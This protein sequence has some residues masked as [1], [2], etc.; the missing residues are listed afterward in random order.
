LSRVH[1]YAIGMDDDDAGTVQRRLVAAVRAVRN[2]PRATVNANSG[3]MRPGE[4]RSERGWLTIQR[5][6]DFVRLKLEDG[7]ARTTF[8][9]LDRTIGEGPDGR[10][11]P[12]S[13]EEIIEAWRRMLEAPFGHALNPEGLSAWRAAVKD[14][15]VLCA[16]IV[17]SAGARFDA[18][19]ELATPGRGLTLGERDTGV[20]GGVFVERVNAIVSAAS[21]MT[22]VMKYEVTNGHSSVSFEGSS[23]LPEDEEV[24]IE[25]ETWPDAIASMR[26][27]TLLDGVPRPWTHLENEK[28]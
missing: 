21:P 6:E 15:E 13:D 5:S 22:V 25:P 28:V 16:S 4:S 10:G 9:V 19:I 17:G 3:Y 24:R 12:Q 14:A 8:Q 20:P 23:E 1:V 7:A 26:A 27:L 18:D 11:L 2:W